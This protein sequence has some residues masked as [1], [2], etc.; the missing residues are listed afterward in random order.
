MSA[1]QVARNIAVG[2]GYLAEFFI[3]ALGFKDFSL[4]DK[5]IDEFV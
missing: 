3:L 5:K 1:S 4:K 2:H